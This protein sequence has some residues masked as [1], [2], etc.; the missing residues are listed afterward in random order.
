MAV[1]SLKSPTIRV[2]RSASADIL[3]QGDE[4]LLV[5]GRHGRDQISAAA[6]GGWTSLC[7]SCFDEEQ[8]ALG[9]AAKPAFSRPDADID[10]AGR[11]AVS[12]DGIG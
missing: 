4:R 2:S 5:V 9:P 11:P 8:A 12:D 10:L 6:E 7:A 1:D 3:Q